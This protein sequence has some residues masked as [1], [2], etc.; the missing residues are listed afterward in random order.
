GDR[1]LHAGEREAARQFHAS[2]LFALQATIGSAQ[3][4]QH[5][6]RLLARFQIVQVR[7]F[8]WASMMVHG[9]YAK[10]SHRYLIIILIAERHAAPATPASAP[11]AAGGHPARRARSAA[12]ECRAA[13][14]DPAPPGAAS[15]PAGWPM[16]PRSCSRPPARWRTPSHDR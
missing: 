6:A 9:V 15:A 12:P 14:P 11:P 13:Q 7:H 10:R 1:F 3:G 16:H 2:R 4:P 8:G 5:E